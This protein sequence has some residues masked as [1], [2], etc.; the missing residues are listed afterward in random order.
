V[1]EGL[2][3]MEESCKIR[4]PGSHEKEREEEEREDERERHDLAGQGVR[5]MD[6]EEGRLQ[7]RSIVLSG[8]RQGNEKSATIGRTAGQLV[9]IE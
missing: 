8:R 5:L 4:V 1:A 2:D 3:F 9:P 7:S 6:M